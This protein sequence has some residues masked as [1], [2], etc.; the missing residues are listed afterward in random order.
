[1]AEENQERKDTGRTHKIVGYGG[2][3]LGALALISQL[4][5]S[6]ITREEG[7]ALSEKIVDLKTT[8]TSQFSELRIFISN[9]Q[10]EQVRK[11]ER[12][13]DKLVERMKETE[14]RSVKAEDIINLRINNLE[15]L[16]KFKPRG[17]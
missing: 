7:T 15:S 2:G 8:Q 9:G 4:K 16:L 1:M 11:L 14:S 17:G 3:V 5:G 13:N 6:F 12:S 10:E